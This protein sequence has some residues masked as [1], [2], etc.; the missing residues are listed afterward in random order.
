MEESVTLVPGR[1]AL[2]SA[3]LEVTAVSCLQKSM[4]VLEMADLELKH[5]DSTHSLG[6]ERGEGGGVGE[7]R[8]VTFIYEFNLLA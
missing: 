7:K 6:P 3:S 8:R 1:A 5:P 4:W 2:P